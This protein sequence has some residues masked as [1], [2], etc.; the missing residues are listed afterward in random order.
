MR[1]MKSRD[2][3]LIALMAAVMAILAPLSIPVGEVPITLGTL[4]VCLMGA[5]LGAKKGTLAVCLYLL[6]GVAGLPVFASGRSG[7]QTLFGLT[8]GFIIG[9]IP[10]AALTGLGI[11]LGK[12]KYASYPLSMIVG[13]LAC[14]SAGVT[15][16]I[17]QNP[18]PVLH[19]LQICVFPFMGVDICKIAAASV[20]AVSV[21]KRI[22]YLP[23][24]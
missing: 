1:S 5:I 7:I 19:A 8:G 12:K 24:G 16:F 10:L 21:Q 4:V 9:Y 17:I 11:S 13:T 23:E 14:Y 15:W 2:M 20:L 18:C 3:C 22:R 6:M